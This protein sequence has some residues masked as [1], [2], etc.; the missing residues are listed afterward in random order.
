MFDK[1]EK[2]KP[3]ERGIRVNPKDATQVFRNKINFS[4]QKNT[5][6][7]SHMDKILN[8]DFCFT[9]TEVPYGNI[10]I[11]NPHVT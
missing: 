1:E 5:F 2:G 6:D 11:K 4:L 10:K 7:A 9:K 3:S 8:S